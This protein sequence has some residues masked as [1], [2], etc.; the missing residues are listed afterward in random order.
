M[1]VFLCQ[2][3]RNLQTT[4]CL[5][6]TTSRGVYACQPPCVVCRQDPTHMDLENVASRQNVRTSMLDI[7]AIMTVRRGP[8]ITS[9]PLGIGLST[10]WGP[11]EVGV[12]QYSLSS[13]N[14]MPCAVTERESV[15]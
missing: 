10:P 5:L 13:C 15:R 12:V 3:S 4:W 11:P 6:G 8:G 9:C 1:R 7:D 14:Q 2:R